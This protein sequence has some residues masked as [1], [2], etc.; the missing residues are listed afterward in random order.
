MSDYEMIKSENKIF[1]SNILDIR[2]DVKGGV[3]FKDI[4][5]DVSLL[6]PKLK[7]NN[8]MITYL[9]KYTR[10]LF[11][12][13]K[14]PMKYTSFLIKKDNNTNSSRTS[15]MSN[16]DNLKTRRKR[17]S[18]Y[19]YKL[20]KHAM[21]K[22]KIITKHD[23][24]KALENMNANIEFMKSL[25]FKQKKSIHLQK[26]KYLIFKAEK[27]IT[28]KLVFTKS[29]NTELNG[30]YERLSHVL[31]RRPI[32]KNKE[33]KYFL[34]YY[35]G[36][37]EGE[38]RYAHAWYIDNIYKKK[39]GPIEPE[40]D[41]VI[42]DFN[43]TIKE[44]RGYELGKKYDDYKNSKGWVIAKLNHVNELKRYNKED[45]KKEKKGKNDVF[46]K[47]KHLTPDSI[48][49]WLDIKD[50]PVEGELTT[51]NKNNEQYVDG[52]I[53]TSNIKSKPEWV[54]KISKRDGNIQIKM[55]L[56]VTS[57]FNRE[58]SF[59]KLDCADKEKILKKEIDHIMGWT[60]YTETSG[61]K[62]LQEQEKNKTGGTRKKKYKLSRKTRKN[63][64]K[65]S[66]LF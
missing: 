43:V 1:V 61:N 58:E 25:L 60:D 34:F 53:T 40:I 4:P 28:K 38:L 45:K 39:L 9:F 19:F 3:K 24:A 17:G 2:M 5:F 15:F 27:G 50:N 48:Y 49:T 51:S 64:N 47:S 13:A 59:A 26:Q 44:L 29:K 42:T 31:H 8:I 56:H 11:K 46:S 20:V 55:V 52:K 63:R 36:V 37:M 7:D 54:K 62:K 10:E 41:F 18:H 14:V 12:E 65:R 16:T 35:N 57:R 33:N 21:K 22:N 6:N 23:S 30:E 32:Y 66:C